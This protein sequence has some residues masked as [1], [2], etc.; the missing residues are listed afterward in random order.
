MQDSVCRYSE[1]F[2]LHV[3]RELETGKLPS[4]SAAQERYGIAGNGT[5][6]GWVKR[7]GRS[8]LMP[9]RVR[10]EMPEEKDQLKAMK[11][12]IRELEKALADAHVQQVLAQAYFEVL[13][14]E[15][16]ITDVEEYKKK[17]ARQLF[18]EDEK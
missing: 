12:R 10:I 18:D 11:K 14:E 15:A 1:A 5:I 4:I 8:D 2:K 7:Y 13:C 6:P 3:V 17:R 16:G 9:R